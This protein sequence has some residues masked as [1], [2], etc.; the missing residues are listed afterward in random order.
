MLV[1]IIFALLLVLGILFWTGRAAAL[2]P[3]HI[4]LGLLLVVCLLFLAAVALIRR[5][6][7]GFALLLVACALVLPVLGLTQD[8]LL[9]GSGHWLVQVLHVL[10][11][12]AA[13]G[14]A[15]VVAGRA[16]VSGGKAG[17]RR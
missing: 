4:L 11:G 5:T 8:Q 12:V 15:E 3:L 13:V 2:V 16:R 7:P 10:L 1:R 9:I 17:T 14:L 6:S